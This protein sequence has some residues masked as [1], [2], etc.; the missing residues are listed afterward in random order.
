[1]H[2]IQTTAEQLITSTG[3]KQPYETYVA[4]LTTAAQKIHGTIPSTPAR[5]STNLH[6]QFAVEQD[7]YDDPFPGDGE[8]YDVNSPVEVILANAHARLPK[9]RT[10]AIL[11]QD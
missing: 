7:S 10:G 5:C 6:E 3:S 1:M 2:S 9:Q 4:L 8:E 11:L